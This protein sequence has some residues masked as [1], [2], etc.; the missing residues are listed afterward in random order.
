[1]TLDLIEIDNIKFGFNDLDVID[2][3][4]MKIKSG[5]IQALLG[6]N[7]VG[8]TVFNRLL[9]LIIQ[10]E[11]GEIRWDGQVVSPISNGKNVETIRKIGYLWQH[12][13]FISSNL[14]K[15][16]EYP[17]LL[18]DIP[19]EQRKK[20]V[21]DQIKEFRL[22]EYQYK[23]PNQLS[24]GTLQRAA[25]ARTLITKP[26]LVILDEPAASLDMA[27]IKWLE[28]YLKDYSREVKPVIIWTTHDQFQARRIAKIVNILMDG[29]V[30]SGDMQTLEEKG[31]AKVRNYL[32]GKLVV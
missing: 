32:Q 13:V 11:S 1:M 23:K 27:T 31:S 28:Q 18:R 3:L 20:L 6:P 14:R 4:S 29:I 30:E 15:N 21:D 26:Q 25:L 5:E 24:I 2:G 17:L 9:S 12:P 10:P 16:I 22:G 19:K 8:K 7:G